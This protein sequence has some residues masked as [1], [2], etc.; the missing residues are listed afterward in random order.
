MAGGRPQ[1]LTV[2]MT[3]LEQIAYQELSSHLT[4]LS[5]MAVTLA[6]GCRD[7]DGRIVVDEGRMRDRLL[8]ELV[9]FIRWSRVVC[10]PLY[11]SELQGSPPDRK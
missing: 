3:A 9:E 5:A 8:H 7:A 10:H 6:S 11:S 2:E 4:G 1:G